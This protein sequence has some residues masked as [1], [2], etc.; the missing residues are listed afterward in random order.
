M[1]K[2]V[3]ILFE[4]I[5]RNLFRKATE[6]WQPHQDASGD[7]GRKANVKV[8]TLRSRLFGISRK[9]RTSRS[10]VITA[11]ATGLQFDVQDH[12][13]EVSHLPQGFM[14]SKTSQSYV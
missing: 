6:M 2:N 8:E 4:N 13:L 12:V 10:H 1:A 7:L 14:H 9:P 11:L 3:T 5:N